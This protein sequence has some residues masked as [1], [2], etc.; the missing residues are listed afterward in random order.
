VIDPG[1]RLA[2]N[3]KVPF[4]RAPAVDVYRST[5]RLADSFH[6]HVLAIEITVH[7]MKMMHATS[8]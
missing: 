5:Q 7:I 8:T 2:E 3:P 4:K 6:G 1:K